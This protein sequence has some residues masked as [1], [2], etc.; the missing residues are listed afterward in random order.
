MPTYEYEC[1]KCGRF[2]KVQPI[3]A[4]ALKTCPTCGSSVRRLISRNVNIVFKGSGFHVTDYR[5]ESYKRAAKADSAGSN[6][7]D[8]SS[9][10]SESGASAE[11]KKS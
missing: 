4:E 10:Y 8:K 5:S 2:E 1:Q 7:V 6:G 9:S 11:G 3:T